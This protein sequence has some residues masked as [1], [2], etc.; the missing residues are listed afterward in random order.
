M[1]KRKLNFSKPSEVKYKC[2]LCSEKGITL[3]NKRCPRCNGKGYL[4]KQVRAGNYQEQTCDICSG[5][6]YN[7]FN[8]NECIS[9]QG[10][11]KIILNMKGSKMVKIYS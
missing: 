5:T 8:K 9:C 10:T 3:E 7:P 6:G 11:G 4:T 2:N 1:E